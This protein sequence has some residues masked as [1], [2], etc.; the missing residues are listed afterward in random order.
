MLYW[1]EGAKQ[2]NSIIFVNS[3]PD[4]M[5]AFIQFLRQE[6]NVTNKIIRLQI[7]CHTHDE[8]EKERIGNYWLDLLGL[9]PANLRNIQTKKGSDTRKNILHNGVCA[10]TVHNTRLAMHIYGAIQEYGG[11]ERPE[12]LF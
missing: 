7:H 2:R 8:R 12:W 11:F 1:A 6:L 9:K 10:L 5:L 4:M 3:D